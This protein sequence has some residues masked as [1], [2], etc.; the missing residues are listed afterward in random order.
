M[1]QKSQRGGNTKPLS[2]YRLRRFVLTV[3]NYTDDE[4]AHLYQLL[5]LKKW[6]FIVG[7]EV[8][9]EG[10]PHL[11]CYVESKNQV[12]FSQLKQMFPRAHIEKARG[13]AKA[14]FEY[15]SKE[16]NFTT[17]MNVKEFD[18]NRYLLQKKYSNVKW[19][20]WQKD[21]LSIIDK[22]PDDRTVYWY[23]D[24][25]GNAGK[26][27]LTKY[28]MLSRKD[29]T[30]IAGKATDAFHGIINFF[31]ETKER[32]RVVIFDI[33]RC[34]DH[35]SFQAIEKVKDGMFFSGKYE[36]K[37]FVMEEPH[38]F[39]FSNQRPDTTKLSADRWK[40]ETITE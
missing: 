14:N 18:Y 19:K 3:N 2:S 15:C 4:V 31:E 34:V 36:S 10:T 22:K 35:I 20:K 1:S 29:T 12:R 27:F 6:K 17:N 37:A 21:V 24:E 40:I 30:I 38:V 5:D 33:P 11:Q 16:G 8:G 25:T 39:V 32:P 7:K 9:A 23:I 13:N 28:L 26:T